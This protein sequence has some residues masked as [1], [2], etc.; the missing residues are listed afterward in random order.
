MVCCFPNPARTLAA[1]CALPGSCVGAFD[2]NGAVMR[3]A[4][5]MSGFG[6]DARLTSARVLPRVERIGFHFLFSVVGT[7]DLTLAVAC[8]IHRA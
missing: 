2:R 8:G 4:S 3:A 1:C 6:W 5:V 7:G